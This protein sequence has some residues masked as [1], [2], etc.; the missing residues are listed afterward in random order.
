MTQKCLLNCSI[1]DK[2]TPK[3]IRLPLKPSCSISLDLLKDPDKSRIN[4]VVKNCLV[5]RLS[6]HHHNDKT[7]RKFTSHKSNDKA[8]TRLNF[9]T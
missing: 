5:K 1:A 2:L 7:K 4:F 3:N 6:Y 9:Q 8:K